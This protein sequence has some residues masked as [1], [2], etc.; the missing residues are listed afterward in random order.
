MQRE[1]NGLAPACA[2]RQRAGK[3]PSSVSGPST[4]PPPDPPLAGA[5]ERSSSRHGSSGGQPGRRP[6]SRHI[7][8][9]SGLDHLELAESRCV[10]Y[11]QR[12]EAPL[13]NWAALTAQNDLLR[14]LLD[15]GAS[16]NNLDSV[17]APLSVR[18]WQHCS[19]PCWCILG[20]TV[21]RPA[22]W[23]WQ[24]GVATPASAARRPGTTMPLLE[25]GQGAKLHSC[26]GVLSLRSMG[27]PRWEPR[28]TSPTAS[29]S[30]CCWLRAPTQAFPTE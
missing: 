4:P 20:T 17:S 15:K 1:S 7:L 12:E 23:G 27:R 21:A 18:V 19:L 28:A 22:S 29:G 10:P 13:V 30:G 24:L 3:R 26:L 5:R 8:R 6:A 14:M 11:A 9:S 25:R 16:P 2:R